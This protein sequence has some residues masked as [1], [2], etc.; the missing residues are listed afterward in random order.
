MRN[1]IWALKCRDFYERGEIPKNKIV[2]VIGGAGHQFFDFF[3][4]Y[5]EI[6]RRYWH[7]FG[8]KKVA[9]EFSGGDAGWVYQSYVYDSATKKGKIITHGSLKELVA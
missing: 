8:Y 4:R 7:I 1:I 2:N 9:A 6:A 5:P 3:I